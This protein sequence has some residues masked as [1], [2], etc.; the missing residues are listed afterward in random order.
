MH[1]HLL[2]C[3]LLLVCNCISLPAQVTPLTIRRAEPP[4]ANAT[5][6]ELERTGDRLQIEESHLDALDYYQASLAKRPANARVHNKI[7]ILELQMQHYS[8][9]SR[10]FKKAIKIEPRFA[11]AY[12]NLGSVY[13][14]QRNYNAAIKQYRKAIQLDPAVAS[15]HANIGAAYFAKKEFESA[16]TSYARALELDPEVLERHARSGI[17]NQLPHSVDLA[18]YAFILAKLY[19]KTGSIDLS[20]ENL[21]RAMAEGYK[22]MYEVLNDP[23]FANVRKDPR[24]VDL[25]TIQP[26]AFMEPPH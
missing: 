19:A 7:G 1:R 3:A 20:L 21:Q 25:I 8:D 12:N 23:D 10:H 6:E 18:Q 15:F 2:F 14:G 11:S 24:F 13:Y 4:A 5:A 22:T 16:S 17:A 9:A 26:S